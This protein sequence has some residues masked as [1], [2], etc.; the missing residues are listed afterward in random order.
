MAIFETTEQWRKEEGIKLCQQVRSDLANRSDWESQRLE[1]R[2]LYYGN[3]TRPDI[4]FEGATDI[5]LP[6]LHENLERLVPKMTNAFWNVWPHVV[7]DRVPE[8]F[9]P[10]DT[11]LQ[12]HFINWAI[13]YDIPRF[14]LTTHG[15]F[16]NMLLDGV[17]QVKTGWVTKWRRTCEIHR[18]KTHMRRGDSMSTGVVVQ[19]EMQ[20]KTGVDV[21]DELFG[22]QGWMPVEEAE[23]GIL[24]TLIEDRRIIE[25]VRVVFTDKSQFIDEVELLVHRPILVEDNPHVDVVEAENLVV[26]H[27][28]RDLQSARRITHIHYMSIDKIKHEAHPARFDAWSV[29]PEDLVHLEAVA[30][31]T[32]DKKPVIENERMARHKDDVEGTRDSKSATESVEI[33]MYEVYRT[34][35]LDQDGMPEEYVIQ[36]SPDLQKIL[37]ITYLDTLHP[38]GRR[39][40]SSIH[41]QAPTDRY[42]VPG[43]AFHLAPINIQANITINQINDR[44]TLVNNPIGFYRPMSLPQ[45]PDAVTHLHPGDMIPSPDPSGIVFPSWGVDP[46][47]DMAIMDVALSMADRVGVSP[48]TGG[49]TNTPNAP[50][51]ARG[52]LAL[53]SEGN[54][55]VDIIVSLAQKEGFQELMQQLFGLYSVFMPDEKYFWATGGDRKKR[56]ELMSRRLMRGRFQFRFRGNTVNTNPEVQRTLSQIRYQVASTNPLYQSD[57]VKFRELLRD[58]LDAHSDGT[59]VERILPDL[60]GM[61]PESHPPMDQKQEITAMRLHQ[62]VPPLNSDD[63]LQHMADIDAFVA[64]P[65]F[66]QLDEVA[67]SFIAQ[68]Y[69][70]HKQ[71]YQRAQ[72]Q[73]QVQAISAGGGEQS[74]GSEMMDVGMGQFEGGV[75]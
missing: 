29:S 37:H 50:R 16:R 72:Q 52:T 45:D 25:N 47:R 34:M 26:P 2:A 61:G 8:D 62:M 27:R 20:E 32:E 28:T 71:M 3:V 73:A 43:L 35:D 6:V 67:V 41:Y 7:V 13:D 74:V 38:H 30:T 18:V 14:Y 48:L 19:Q 68:H 51:T 17:S 49:S 1:A 46:L 11:R 55:K 56:P 33:A 40:F 66:E 9:D 5:H 54:L 10:E 75:Q 64:N 22:P 70:A 58:F 24:V 15:W 42:Y 63:H 53:I 39:P 59:S 31:G 69:Q 44:M 12:E 60:P 36:V 65:A 4:H 57:P 23:D 21:L